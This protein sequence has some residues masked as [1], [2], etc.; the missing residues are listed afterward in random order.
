MD[1]QALVA[2]NFLVFAVLVFVAIMLMLDGLYL[3][4][5]GHKGPEATRLRRRLLSLAAFDDRSAPAR[6]LKQRLLGESAGMQRLLLRMPRL[7]ALDRWMLQAGVGWTVSGLLLSS[8]L[9]WLAG[10]ILAGELTLLGTGACL[11]VGLVPAALPALV[12][13]IRRKRRMRRLEQQ[14]PDTLDLMARSLR[15]GHAF[16]AGLKMA[17]DEMPEP[18]AGEFRAVH[19]EVNFGISLQ[20]ALTHLAERV[21]LIDLRYFVVAVL[22]QRES[23]GNLAEI[24]TELGRLIRERGKLLD[25]VRVL[26]TEGR[27]SAW[28]LGLM[29]F[30]L[31]GVIYLFNPKF[32]SLLWTDPIGV[33]I[34]KFMLIL[35]LVGALVM[36]R[37]VRIHV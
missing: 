34:T 5:R 32:I 16:T 30:F 7:H 17:G 6:V 37:I 31:A 13:H 9:L 28:I 2:N 20:Q 14:L 3:I 36:R 25:R 29:P 19:D 22:V 8:L 23:G 35:M 21:P 10:A 4:W 18:I 11:A 15:A 1:V 26:S 33:S 27:F 12:V 24:L